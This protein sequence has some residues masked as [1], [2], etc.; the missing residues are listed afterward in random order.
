MG[1][2]GF[3]SA[4]R[5]TVKR[6]V[7]CKQPSNNGV[8]DGYAERKFGVFFLI[9]L[10]HLLMA[11]TVDRHHRYCCGFCCCWTYWFIMFT[12]TN[13]WSPQLVNIFRSHARMPSIAHCH[14]YREQTRI[15]ASLFLCHAA[16]NLL[17]RRGGV[18]VQALRK[19]KKIDQSFVYR[20]SISSNVP[21][22]RR[23]TFTRHLS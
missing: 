20:S 3:L 5:Y 6:R 2:P 16:G 18:L 17:Y 22:T 11:A 19:P 1:C 15:W 8:S 14:I 13:C 21:V 23:N 9:E 12:N 10:A 7:I 4:T